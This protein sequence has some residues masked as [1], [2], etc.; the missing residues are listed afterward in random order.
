[1]KLASTSSGEEEYKEIVRGTKSLIR[2]VD[3][4]GEM[5]PTTVDEKLLSDAQVALRNV[6]AGIN[7]AFDHIRRHSKIDLR[8]YGH[9]GISGFT[10]Y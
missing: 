8:W 5:S 2:C 10:Q 1:M 3:G 9:G 7:P 4:W 6:V